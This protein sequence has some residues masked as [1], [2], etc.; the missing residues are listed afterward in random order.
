MRLTITPHDAPDKTEH[1][2]LMKARIEIAG[3]ANDGRMRR[4]AR[5]RCWEQDSGKIAMR[6]VLT[7]KYLTHIL[8]ANYN[9]QHSMKVGVPM[10][11][12]L[13][14]RRIKALREE[15]KLSQETLAEMFGF[16]DRQ[17]VSAIETGARRVTADEL[18]LA[19]ERFGVPFEFFTDPFLLAGEGEVLLAAD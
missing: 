8:L 15:R 9:M 16:N 10:S 7:A 4:R 6:V 11:T 1:G 17:T 13:I 12:R 19:V 3:G 2:N 18:V 5:Q 14:G